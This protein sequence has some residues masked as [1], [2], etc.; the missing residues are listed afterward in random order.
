MS[1]IERSAYVNYSCEQ[2]FDLVNDI[3][4]YPQFLPGC[5][6][7]ALVSQTE[8]T[9]VA[10]LEVGKG[11]VKQSFTTKNTL[12]NQNRIEMNLL[13]GPF[14]KLNGVWVFTQ[15]SDDSCKIALSLEF[16]L[17]GMLKLAFGGVFSQVAN[18]MVEAF[19]NR[20]KVV[21]GG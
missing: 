17:N 18:S 9:I 3:K 1:K 8:G 12:L 16:E 6:S 2:M 21:Y 20:A 15:L 7:S 19:S 14:K 11:P 10:T 4:A 13:E 5:L